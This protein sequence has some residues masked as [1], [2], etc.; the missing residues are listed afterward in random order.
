[1]GLSSIARAIKRRFAGYAVR[2]SERFSATLSSIQPGQICLDCGAN[3]GSYTLLMAKTGAE[4]Y[5]FEPDPRA[6]QVLA[7]RTKKYRNV[8]LYQSAVSNIDGAADLYFHKDRAKD[9]VYFSQGSSLLR[10]KT[11][12]GEGST[13]VTTID[14]AQ[15]IISLN[16][17]IVMKMDIEGAEIEVINSLIDRGA[18]DAISMAFVELHDKK[19]PQL[20]V[21]TA[22]LT[23]RLAPYSDRFDLSWH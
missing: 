4:V 3:V 6:F 9:P 18:V 16:A 21:P 23:Q 8:H 14:L 13:R 12:V 20:V 7:Q 17:P 1:M 22:E 2:P 11:N 5:A 19:N 15:F 10:E